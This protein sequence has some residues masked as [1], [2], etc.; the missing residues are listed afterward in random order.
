MN[1]IRRGLTL[2]ELMIALAIVGLLLTLAAPSFYN[3]ILMQRLKGVSQQLVTDLQFARS[4]AASRNEFVR[5]RFSESATQTCYAIFTGPADNSCS[6]LN[7]TPCPAGSNEIKTVRLPSNQ[8]VLVTAVSIPR[9]M[10]FEPANGAMATPA[11]DLTGLPAQAFV[12]DVFID[13]SRRLRT[14]IQRSGRPSVCV[15]AGSTMQGLACS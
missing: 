1:K 14:E 6:C 12:I 7:A 13:A 15:P 5:V 2:V 9:M 3:Y 10:R 4:E 8:R 11:V